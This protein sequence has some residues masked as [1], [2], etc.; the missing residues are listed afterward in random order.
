[1]K[2][3]QGINSMLKLVNLTSFNDK[4][5]PTQIAYFHENL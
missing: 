4:L 3:E 1:M 2:E 5:E